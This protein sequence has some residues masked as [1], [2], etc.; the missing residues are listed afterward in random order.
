MV[1]SALKTCNGPVGTF[2][3]AHGLM[4]SRDVRKVAAIST[5]PH[6]LIAFNLTSFIL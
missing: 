2:D 4:G 1:S 6:R 5:A 3:T